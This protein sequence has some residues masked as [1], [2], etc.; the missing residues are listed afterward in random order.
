MKSLFWNLR[1]L[2][3]SPTRLALKRF[4]LLHKPDFCFVSE[5]WMHI[6]N[7]PRGSF[8]RIG[9]KLFA[10]N[11]RNDLLPNLWCICTKNMNPAIVSISDQMV[12][13]TFNHN[14]IVG[15]MIAEY[16]STCY[17]KR[18]ELWNSLNLIQ[19]QQNIPWCFMGDFNS[20]MGA[21]EHRGFHSPARAPIEDF[22]AWTSSNNLI[23]LP[24]VGPA[25]TWSRTGRRSI[26]RRLDRSI[27][28]Q[29]WMDMCSSITCSTILKVRSDHHPILLDFQ[30]SQ[31]KF[32]SQ[33]KFMRMWTLHE[34]CRNIVASSWSNVFM[35]CPMYVLSKKLQLL[36]AN[37]KVWNKSVF[38]NVHQLVKEAENKLHDVQQKINIEGYNDTLMQQEKS[39]QK[40]LY[41]ALHKEEVF[42]LEILDEDFR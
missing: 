8:D 17:L 28:N 22:Q 41:E 6:G 2:A 13:F 30:A 5:P 4:L 35:G 24:T 31:H 11:D 1:G 14:G 23:H 39:A 9:Y 12:A 15:G 34:D 38:G 21:H 7:F 10:M 19:Q 16:A 42:W 3:N 27:C 33:F 25:Y 36:K 40:I 20:I 29:L 18:R 26:E 32:T 37:L